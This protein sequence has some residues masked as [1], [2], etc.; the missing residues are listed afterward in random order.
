LNTLRIPRE[1]GEISREIA[2]N[3]AA[4]AAENAGNSVEPALRARLAA[5]WNWLADSVDRG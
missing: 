3:R 5:T 2:A 1:N 4:I